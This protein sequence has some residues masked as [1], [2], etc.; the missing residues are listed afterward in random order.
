MPLIIHNMSMQTFLLH[1]SKLMC[2]FE[3]L[4]IEM[5]HPN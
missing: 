2:S 5:T 1:L 3:L 4:F